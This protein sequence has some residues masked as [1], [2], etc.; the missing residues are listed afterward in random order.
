VL[1]FSFLYTFGGL[2]CDQS[3]TKIVGSKVPFFDE[4]ALGFD[5]NEDTNKHGRFDDLFSIPV[6]TSSFEPFLPTPKRR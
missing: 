3:G 4:G 5:L 6:R 1:D 2:R